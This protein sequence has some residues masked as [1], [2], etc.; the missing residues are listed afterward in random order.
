MCDNGGMI[1]IDWGLSSFR[2]WRLGDDGAPT[3]ALA[4]PRG[5]RGIAREDF[6]GALDAL[7]SPWAGATDDVILLC[8]MIGS[9]Q[10]WAEAPYVPCPARPADIAGALLPLPGRDRAFIVPGLSCRNGGIADV[11]R[12]EETQL[13]GLLPALGDGT[14]RICLPGTHSKWAV[15]ADGAIV[16]FRTAMTGEVFALMRTHSTLAPLMAE[17]EADAAAEDDDAFRAGLARAQTEGGLLSHLFGLRAASL[18]G[19][20]PVRALPPFLSGLLIGHEIAALGAGEGPVHVVG[21]RALV[22]RYARALSVSGR[23]AVRHGEETAAMG[24]WSIARA[25]G[26]A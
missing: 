16:S 4:A 1:A 9:R 10:C 23:Q 21:A 17:A 11:M 3:A 8:G 20:L 6:A 14:H 13:L 25:R 22:D 18:L 12:G 5:I 24:L 19:D 15:V 2:A 26:L 7:L